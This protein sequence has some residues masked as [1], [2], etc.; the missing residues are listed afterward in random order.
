MYSTL[1]DL[2]RPLRSFADRKA[3]FAIVGRA[4]AKVDEAACETPN[5]TKSIDMGFAPVK[6]C[7][8]KCTGIALS[9][10]KKK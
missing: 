6:L 1:M 2:K 8:F 4:E 3:F 9:V 5:E 7:A 10:S